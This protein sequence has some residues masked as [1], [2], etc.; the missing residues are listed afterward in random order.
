MKRQQKN[1]WHLSSTLL[2]PILSHNHSSSAST[3]NHAGDLVRG[4]KPSKTQKSGK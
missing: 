2:I 4:K 3:K 1:L